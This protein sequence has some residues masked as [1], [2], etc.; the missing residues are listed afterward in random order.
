[1]CMP[2]R[3]PNSILR[4][5][6]F[7]SPNKMFKFICAVTTWD[8]KGPV[9]AC[10]AYYWPF[11]MKLC[12]S[13]YTIFLAH[14]I[15]GCMVHPLQISVAHFM[16]FCG[17]RYK[18]CAGLLWIIVVLIF[19]VVFVNFLFTKDGTRSKKTAQVFEFLRSNTQIF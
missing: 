17:P 5:Q 19:E 7:T 3:G 14:F 11:S 6:P 10:W 1:M 9:L 8:Q 15:F 2:S 16:N 12:G 13:F 4:I 18:I